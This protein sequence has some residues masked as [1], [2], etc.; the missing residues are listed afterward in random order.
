MSAVPAAV[1][2]PR[3]V[4]ARRALLTVL[5]LGGF[6]GLALLFG[7]SAHAASGQDGPGSGATSA[8]AGLIEQNDTTDEAADNTSDKAADNTSHEAADDT[9][10]EAADKA[11][12]ATPKAQRATSETARKVID[13]VAKSAER[14]GEITRPVGEAGQGVT[15][16][17]RPG[18]LTERTGLQQGDDSGAGGSAADRGTETTP[19]ASGTRA[20][21]GPNGP[22]RPAAHGTADAEA[23][24]PGPAHHATPSEVTHQGGSPVHPLPPVQQ[25]PAAPASGGSPGAG[26]GH[27]PRGG[28]H[29]LAGVVTGME[30]YGPLCAAGA[31]RAAEGTPTRE[32]CGDVLEFPG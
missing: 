13:P 29:Q 17:V 28:Q 12:G 3:S 15:E 27:G 18:G 30:H 23:A 19:D 16:P 21:Y 14:T 8:T 22:D 5:F 2:L 31:V 1:R 11:G 4:A 9:S 25:G 32:R 6:L 24:D 7:G 20:G 26:D 10:H